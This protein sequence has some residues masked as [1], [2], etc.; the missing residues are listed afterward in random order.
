M[1]RG[2]QPSRCDYYCNKVCAVPVGYRSIIPRNGAAIGMVL[3]ETIATA[4]DAAS[5]VPSPPR[6]TTKF[7]SREAISS[8]GAINRVSRHAAAFV[9]DEKHI[10]E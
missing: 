9:H 6:T 8:R 7:R 4:R 3:A 2:H 5:N 10:N 1:A